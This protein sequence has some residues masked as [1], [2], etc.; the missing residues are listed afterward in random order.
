MMGMHAGHVHLH[1]DVAGLAAVHLPAHHALGVLDGDAAL[2]IL[3]E[4]DEDHQGQHADDDDRDQG[5]PS[6]LFR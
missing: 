1:G 2:G 5:G 4:D 3:D 6:R